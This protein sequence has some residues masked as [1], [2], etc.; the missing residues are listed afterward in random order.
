V[1]GRSGGSPGAV[2]GAA[3]GGA[4]TYAELVE[5]LEAALP[6]D[7]S[8]HWL[9]GHATGVQG[10]PLD[11]DTTLLLSIE[12]DRDLGFGFLDGGTVR[13]RIPPHALARHD[14]SRVIAFG[15]SC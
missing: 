9:G 1:G 3:A 12:D 15:D 5:R 7:E 13:F 8:R 6:A 4:R 11:D 2:R 14:F 10:A